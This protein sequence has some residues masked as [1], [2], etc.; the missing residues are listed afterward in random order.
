[1]LFRSVAELD[2]AERRSF[3]Y[4]FV[5]I[6]NKVAV[7]D[8]MPLSDSETLPT[9]IEKAAAMVSRGLEFVAAENRIAP[10]DA[11]RRVSLEHL[12]RVGANLETETNP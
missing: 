6:A 3:F 9:A 12:F 4:A 2:A 7:A 5:S 10:S 11:L 1:M 8:R